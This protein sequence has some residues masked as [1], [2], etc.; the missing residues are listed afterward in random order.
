MAL[1]PEIRQLLNL[2]S[3]ME[4]PDYS[5]MPPADARRLYRQLA[6]VPADLPTVDVDDSVIAGPQGPLPIRVYRPVGSRPQRA[7][8]WFHGGGWVFGDL[9]SSEVS[10]RALANA[11]GCAVV[12]VDYRL[13]PENPFPAAFDD[14]YAATRWV[15]D[16]GPDL[17]ID[18]NQV[19]VGG[20]SAGANLA[21]AVSL[22]ARNDGIG[23]VHQLLAYPVVAADFDTASYRDNAEGYRLT[24]SAMMW[25]WD[26]YVPDLGQRTDVRVSPVGHDL[27]GVAPAWVFTCGFDPLRDEGRRF[28][29]QLAAAGVA[30]ERYEQSDT[31]HGVFEMDVVRGAD[32]RQAAADALSAAFAANES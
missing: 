21:I 18:P 14:C 11:A 10:N 24:R 2:L 15:I 13:A 27:A 23:L 6:T 28:A 20:G 5:Q 32:A 3:Q 9:D 17:D 1:D 29:D 4:L 8:V 30:V 22:A 19:A 31:V 16:H 12:S 25:F 26:Q 7:L